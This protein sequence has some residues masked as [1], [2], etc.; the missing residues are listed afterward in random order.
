MEDSQI[1]DLYW[2]RDETAITETES[3]Y[4]R[5]CFSIANRILENPEDARECVN[6]TYLGAWNAMPP[7]RPEILS[8]FLGKITRRLSLKKRR[9]RSAEK[10]GGGSVEASIDEL[11]ECLPSGQS[12]DENLAVAELSEIIDSFLEALPQGE[13]RVFLRR[14]WFFDSIR[15]IA[16][17]YG[18]SESKVKMMLKG[19]RDKLLV[20]LQ[21]ED[22][23]V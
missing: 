9:D 15:E 23:W 6:D 4:G 16:L 20:C 1:V 5:F 12:M 18:F 7:H 21:K 8:S 3:K 10:R 13:R 22:I 17:R 2:Q 19:T 14:Y 11:E